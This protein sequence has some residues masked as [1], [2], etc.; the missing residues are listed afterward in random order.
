MAGFQSAFDAQFPKRAGDIKRLADFEKIR[1][2]EFLLICEK[3][4]VFGKT[5]KRQLEARLD[6]RNAAGHPNGVKITKM[7][8]AA[9]IEFLLHN[10]FE[11]FIR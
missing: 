10:V 2:S 1:E 8:A 6:F 4:G 9:H 5:M 11:E 7:Q 3:V